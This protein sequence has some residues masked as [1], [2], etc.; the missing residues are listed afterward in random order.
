MNVSLSTAE[1]E[2]LLEATVAGTLGLA[3]YAAPQ[4]PGDPPATVLK[5]LLCLALLGAECRDRAAELPH[6]QVVSVVRQ[7]NQRI[8]RR[9]A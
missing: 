7:V 8:L 2:A 3:N 4:P 9:F 5:E 1:V 6:S